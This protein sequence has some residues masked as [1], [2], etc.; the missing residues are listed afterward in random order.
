MTA[1]L[2]IPA[3]LLGFLTAVIRYVAF[4]I[5]FTQASLTYFVVTLAAPAVLLWLLKTAEILK[6][7]PVLTAADLQTT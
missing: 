2:I 6:N 4:D 5:T 3:S 1:L 7:R